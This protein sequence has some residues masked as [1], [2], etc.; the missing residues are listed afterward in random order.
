MRFIICFSILF[1]ISACAATP[2]YQYFEGGQSVNQPGVSYNLPKG[3]SW[4][5]IMRTTYQA[6]FGANEMPKNE[7][8]IVT[9]SVYNIPTPTNTKQEFLSIVKEGRVSEPKTGRF[10]TINNNE[11][12]DT[13]RP[14]TC[15]I[16]QSTT[17][18]FGAEAKRGG[19]YSILETYGMNC[20]HPTNSSVG[21]FVELSRKA[22][23]GTTFSDFDTMGST[24]LQSVT[25]GE[26]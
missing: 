12:I 11:Q 1:I 26:F 17:K 10:E 22:P 8:L 24:L 7:T 21:I 2:S 20:I 15:V 18:D 14:E 19:E 4:S 5:A 3:K 23:P 9:N 25:F 13:D 6:V 16:H